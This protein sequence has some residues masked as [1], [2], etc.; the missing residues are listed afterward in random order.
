MLVNQDEV[1]VRIEQHDARRPGAALVGL[2][3]HLESLRL[4]PTLMIAYVGE[5][6]DGPGRVVL[7]WVEGQNIS[8]EHAL[9]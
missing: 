7:T 1:A 5:L 6:F 9:K 4:E 3:R 2:T 8:F